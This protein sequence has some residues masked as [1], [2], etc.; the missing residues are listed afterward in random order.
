MLD[1]Q[2]V[3]YL[4]QVEENSLGVRRRVEHGSKRVSAAATD[5]CDCIE[6]AEVL[7][8]ENCGDVR[9]GFS[10]HRLSEDLRLGRVTLEVGPDAGRF[11]DFQGW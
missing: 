1:G 3:D 6:A 11:N 10:R 7:G 9:A 5:V 8:A 2:A 4:G